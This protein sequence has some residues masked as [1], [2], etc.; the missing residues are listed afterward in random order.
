MNIYTPYTYLIGWSKHNK[1][2]YGRRTSKNCRPNELWK[3]YFTSSKEVK[4]FVSVN[5]EPDIIK[6]RRTFPN[7]PNACKLWESKVLEKLD[8]QH[9]PRFLN[10]KNGDHKWDSTGMVTVKDTNGNT[11]QVSV[12][13]PKLISGELRG[14]AEGKVAVKDING[15]IF[16]VPKNDPRYISG[17]LVS[18]NKGKVSVKDIDGNTFQVSKDDPRYISGELVHVAKGKF[19]A[20]DSNGIIYIITKDDPRWISGELV[21]FNKD[22]KPSK[23]SIE[24]RRSK[25]IGQKRSEETKKKN[26]MNLRNFWASE[27]GKEMKELNSKTI[28][29]MVLESKEFCRIS[30][31]EFYSYKNIKYVA[32]FSKIAREYKSKGD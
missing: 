28:W 19:K 23:E 30:L 27:K 31:E 16:Q 32:G 12:N 4:E 15:N 22:K 6:I 1:F 21:G 7:N 8:A 11:S 26:S 14:I 5:G 29:V 18:V 13:N 2:Y 10:K 9:D 24:L 20:K 25:I 3:T 17:E